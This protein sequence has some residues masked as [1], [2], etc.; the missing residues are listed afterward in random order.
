MRRDRD[1]K[2]LVENLH[3]DLKKEDISCSDLASHPTFERLRNR[4]RSR[5]EALERLANTPGLMGRGEDLSSDAVF[6]AALEGEM[7]GEVGERFVKELRRTLNSVLHLTRFGRDGEVFKQALMS[8]FLLDKGVIQAHPLIRRLFAE[9]VIALNQESPQPAWN[10]PSLFEM[11]AHKKRSEYRCRTTPDLVKDLTEMGMSPHGE[12][13][14]ELARRGQEAMDPLVSL[15]HRKLAEEEE[16]DEAGDGWAVGP[17]CAILGEVGDAQ[18]VETLIRCLRVDPDE[19]IVLALAKIGVGA[20]EGLRDLLMDTEGDLDVRIQAVVALSY[21]AYLHTEAHSE[22]V[23]VLRDL[24]GRDREDDPEVYEWVIHGLGGIGASAECQDDIRKPYE[25]G[26]M[27]EA[28]IDLGDA[29]KGGFGW[30][31]VEEAEEGLLDPYRYVDEEWDEEVEGL[32]PGLG[33]ALLDALSEPQEPVRVGEKVGR[34]D[35]CPCGSGKKYK[36]CCGQ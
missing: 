30:I 20:L 36:R 9:A 16:S 26:L 12:L 18:A 2:K 19:E 21:L 34:N 11:Y 14:A 4:I 32:P 13:V 28:E 22:V 31:S 29:L 17:A 7:A 15:V 6:I 35:P 1:L 23:K 33:D 24:L 3:N 8:L 25:Q 27:N 10:R 5:R